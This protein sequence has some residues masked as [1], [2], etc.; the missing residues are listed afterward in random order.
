MQSGPSS[1]ITWDVWGRQILKYL[2]NLL[3]QNSGDRAQQLCFN[4][5]S[6]LFSWSV[7]SGHYWSSSISTVLSYHRAFQQQHYWHFGL[8]SPLLWGTVLCI[9]ECE[10]HPLL[11]AT[12]WQQ[13]PSTQAWQSQMSIAIAK[14]LMGV[15]KLPLVGKHCL[16]KCSKM[17]RKSKW[18]DFFLIY[19]FQL[20]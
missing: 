4:M 6:G 18:K 13:Q 3:N 1:I 5:A 9:I 10:Q 20:Y 19:Q 11:L 15:A 8:A 7:K 2:P 17:W 12:G 16:E 14:C